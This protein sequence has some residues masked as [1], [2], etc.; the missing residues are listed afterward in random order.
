MPLEA[1]S[2]MYH[3][4]VEPRDSGSSGFRGQSPNRYKLDRPLFERH[5]AAIAA[6]GRAPSSVADLRAGARQQRS[7]KPR[8]LYITFDDGGASAARVGEL[9]AGAGWVGHFFIPVDFIGR[10]GF[11]DRDGVAALSGMGHVIGSHSCSHQVPMAR[12]PE[13][14]LR[15][16]WR[17]SVDVLSEIIG[18]EVFSASVPGGYWSKRVVRSAAASGIEVLFTSDPVVSIRNSDECLLVGRYAILDGTSAETAVRLVRGEL[19]ARRRQLASWIARAVAK[20]VLGDAY[21]SLRV[22]WLERA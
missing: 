12:L 13:E 4:V 21:R 15:E 5:L 9:L 11:L 10:P 1:I 18:S 16:E 22:A 14:R 19:G 2:L 6:A 17:R 7:S 3:D 8:P 20:A